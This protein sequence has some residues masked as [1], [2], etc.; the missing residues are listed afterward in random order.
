MYTSVA[1][2]ACYSCMPI[3]ALSKSQQIKIMW[4]TNKRRSRE[5]AAE[6]VKDTISDRL[7]DRGGLSGYLNWVL[8]ITWSDLIR[9]GL[10]CQFKKHLGTCEW[11]SCQV[12]PSLLG[13]PGSRPQGSTQHIMLSLGRYVSLTTTATTRSSL[14]VGPNTPYLGMQQFI[15]EKNLKPQS[16]CGVLSYHF[17]LWLRT[18]GL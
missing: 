10:K 3:L 15:Q 13:P 4:L 2:L 1:N 17:R 7:T 9:R 5:K 14:P 6:Q 11:V 8:T 16:W 18:L 12:E